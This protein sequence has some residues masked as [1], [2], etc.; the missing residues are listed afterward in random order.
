[1]KSLKTLQERFDEKWKLDPETGCHIWTASKNF[2]G[3]G[4][5]WDG[6]RLRPA[7]AVSYELHIG[8]IPPGHQ[9][10]HADLICPKSCV[11]EEHIVAATKRDLLAKAVTAGRYGH[12]LDSCRRGH[13]RSAANTYTN[14]YSGARQCRVCARITLQ[15]LRAERR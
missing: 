1:M 6:T 12:L 11:N 13:E 14:S 7:H 9:V 4:L 5:F 2:G 15:S 10:G 8:S 3:Y